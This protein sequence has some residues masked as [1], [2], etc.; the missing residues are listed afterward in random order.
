MTTKKT[1]AVEVKENSEP[2][3]ASD[4]IDENVP[5]SLIEDEKA[6]K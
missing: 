2:I 4:R 3:V 1:E 5:A 6:K